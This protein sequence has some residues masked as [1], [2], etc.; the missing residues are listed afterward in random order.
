MGVPFYG[1]VTL[2]GVSPLSL[3]L[4]SLGPFLL[5]VIRSGLLQINLPHLGCSDVPIQ[6]SDLSS[7]VGGGH[8][9]RMR[10]AVCL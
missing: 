9:G 10:L 1:G 7:V 8:H 2:M 4:L 5:G 3:L 6:Q